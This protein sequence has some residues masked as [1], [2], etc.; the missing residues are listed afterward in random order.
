MIESGVLYSCT[1]IVVTATAFIH[2]DGVCI[3]LDLMAQF[4]VS[5]HLV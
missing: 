4:T 3:M 2:T 5:L 1:L